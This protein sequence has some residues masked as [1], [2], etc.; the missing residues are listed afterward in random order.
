M[1]T[2]TYFFVESEGIKLPD[3]TVWGGGKELKFQIMRGE[4]RPDMFTIYEYI[5]K[6]RVAKFNHDNLD[7]KAMKAFV[8]AEL[9]YYE[10]VGM[11]FWAANHSEWDKATYKTLV[12]EEW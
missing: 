4:S 2:A 7:Y 9:H 3:G 10:S 1:T 11:K 6:H 5:G 12:T 8:T